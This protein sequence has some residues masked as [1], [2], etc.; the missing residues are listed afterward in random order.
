VIL[1]APTSNPSI[2]THQMYQVLLDAAAASQQWRNL[3]TTNSRHLRLT[4]ARSMTLTT[5]YLSLHYKNYVL[6][7]Y[8]DG[9]EPHLYGAP[10]TLLSR[11]LHYSITIISLWTPIQNPHTS[12]LHPRLIS[13]PSASTLPSS[14]PSASF[15]LYSVISVP[16]SFPTYPDSRSCAPW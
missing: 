10:T 2:N 7:L 13:H 12:P 9:L 3:M 16:C 15:P 14:T 1:L 6:N 11:N 5:L 4:S 8:Q